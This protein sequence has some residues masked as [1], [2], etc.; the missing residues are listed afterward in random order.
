MPVCV[1]GDKMLLDGIMVLC[2]VNIASTGG[3]FSSRARLAARI[4]D[5]PESRHTFV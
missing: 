1:L 3:S 5:A 4:I 2:A